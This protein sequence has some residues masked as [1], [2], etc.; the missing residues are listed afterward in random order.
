MTTMKDLSKSKLNQITLIYLIE[1]L[2][3]NIQFPGL[4]FLKIKEFTNLSQRFKK[5]YNAEI[6][7]FGQAPF[8]NIQIHHHMHHHFRYRRYRAER[9]WL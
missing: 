3:R 2:N 9:V 7:L 4:P 6:G 8:S 1:C 5:W